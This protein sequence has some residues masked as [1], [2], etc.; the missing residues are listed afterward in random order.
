MPLYD[1]EC[2]S[3]HHQF[4]KVTFYSTRR[5]SCTKCGGRAEKIITK[6]PLRTYS[7]RPQ[8]RLWGTSHWKS[9]KKKGGKR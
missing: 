9:D 4:E 3:C 6:M 5:V 2:E 8:D 7:K 1:W